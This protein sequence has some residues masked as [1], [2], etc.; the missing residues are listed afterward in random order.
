[1][2]DVTEILHDKWNSLLA[3]TVV[4]CWLKADILPREHCNVL[5]GM[6]SRLDREDTDEGD[7]AIIDDLCDMVKQSKCRCQPASRTLGPRLTC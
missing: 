5:K 2:L 3:Q 4:R 1:M 7:K 6:D